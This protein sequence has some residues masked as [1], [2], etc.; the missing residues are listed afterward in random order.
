MD[1][2]LRY[3]DIDIGILI[4]LGVLLGIV[5]GWSM[6]SCQPTTPEQEW[7]LESCP[8]GFKEQFILKEYWQGNKDLALCVCEEPCTFTGGIYPRIFERRICMT[9]V[10]YDMLITDNICIENKCRNES[11]WNNVTQEKCGWRV[12]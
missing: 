3:N 7:Y 6:F 8:G 2:K 12:N 9:A 10:K 11:Y 5:L 4:T 1:K